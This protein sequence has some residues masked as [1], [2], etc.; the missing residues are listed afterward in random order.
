MKRKDLRISVVSSGPLEEA[1][2]NTIAAV[3]V[4]N[5]IWKRPPLQEQADKPATT[6]AQTANPREQQANLSDPMLVSWLAT[7]IVVPSSSHL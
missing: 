2:D 4:S 1:G 3:R 7:V 6:A 5:C